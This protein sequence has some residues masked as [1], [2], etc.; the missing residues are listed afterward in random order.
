MLTVDFERLGLQPGDRVLDLGCGGGRHAFESFRRGASVVAFDADFVELKGVTGLVQAMAEAGEAG[1]GARSM[2]VQGTAFQLPFPD[3]SF[4][5]II[6]AE[7]LEHLPNDHV[8]ISELARVLKPTGRMAVTVPRYGPEMIN[9]A[10][11]EEYHSVPG[12]HIR[13]Y[14]RSQLLARLQSSGLRILATHHAHALHSPYWWLKCL[15]G[16]SNDQ[17]RAVRAYHQLLVWDIMKRPALTRVSE[18]V[19]NPL[20]GKSFVVYVEHAS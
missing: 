2:E 6:A 13:I 4:D 11:S 7:V 9:W 1:E 16:T 18:Q 17:H 10:L 12:G 15:V 3:D 19:L 5:R 8:A 14:R 20:I